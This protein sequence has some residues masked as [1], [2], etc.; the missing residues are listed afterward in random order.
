MQLTSIQTVKNLLEK[1]GFTFSKS[2]GQNFL[3]NPTVCPKIAEMGGAKQGVS[4]IEIGTGIG[5]LTKELALRC[6][7]V[8][9][10]EIDTR[11]KPVLEET[12]ASFENVT[13]VFE[14]VLKANLSALIE[15][16]LA[17]AKEIVV[18]ANLPYY[19]TS[20]VIMG[21]LE[22]RLPISRITVMVQKE[23]AQRICALPGTKE[24]GAVSVAVRY[25]SE[26]K[27]LFQVSRGSFLPSPNVDSTVISLNLH[28]ENPYRVSDEA[29]F[30]KLVRSAFSQ[31]RKQM[32]NPVS[33]TFGIPKQT[34]S[35]WMTQ[36][37]I[38]VTAR[39]EELKMEDF[40]RL[41]DFIKNNGVG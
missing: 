15:Q 27:Q 2:L 12:L 17:G 40:V 8:L 26:P 36:C 38:S 10:I 25:Y 7:N 11:L 33:Q 23:A 5:V 3:V 29:L 37:R 9:A 28:K 14:D 31:R 19:I 32:I 34:L 24:C 41:A 6:D 16:H 20:P 13:I 30:F 1:N 35:D 39:A 18:C 21:L 4:A 22:Q